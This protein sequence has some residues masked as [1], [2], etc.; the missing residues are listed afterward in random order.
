MLIADEFVFVTPTRVSI[1]D[2][3]LLIFVVF[4]LIEAVFAATLLFNDVMSEVFVL[5]SVIT[6]V[7]WDKFT[8]CD[9]E[10]P[11]A[12]PVILFEF[13]LKFPDAGIEPS[14][15]KYGE[16]SGAAG[17]W[18]K[19]T[20]SVAAV[21]FARPVILLLF[22]S[23]SPVAAMLPFFSKYGDK[24]GIIAVNWLKFTASLD[25]DAFDTFL[26]WL[27]LI[28]RAAPILFDPSVFKKPVTSGITL[29]TYCLLVAS[30]LFVGVPKLTIFAL[31]M[32][33]CPSNELV[34]FTVKSA[35]INISFAVLSPN[36]VSPLSDL[37]FLVGSPF[38]FI[39]LIYRKVFKV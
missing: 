9:D 38:I 25:A 16:R 39:Y 33:S 26:I 28:F 23:N 14:F 10:E 29:S 27:L 37:S 7:N 2:E 5:T 12:R 6:A 24:S 18:L 19:F 36:D 22:K 20:A 8:A 34:P 3:L 21:P 1:V 35:S 13:I 11:F 15:S 31:F 30:P 32:S 4:V 17:I